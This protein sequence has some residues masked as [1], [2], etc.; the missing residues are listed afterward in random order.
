[1]QKLPTC[2]GLLR[3]MQLE[4]LLLASA[5]VFLLLHTACLCEA[6]ALRACLCFVTQQTYVGPG[7]CPA[8]AQHAQSV[9]RHD[10]RDFFARSA[11]LLLLDCA[12]AACVCALSV[13]AGIAASV[14]S[15]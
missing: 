13:I 4:T 7:A 11:L 8:R 9:T 14:L 15:C 1:M 5:S 3:P 12:L 2:R 10:V 6:Q